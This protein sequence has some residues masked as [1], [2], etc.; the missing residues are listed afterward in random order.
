VVAG[1][2]SECCCDVTGGATLDVTSFVTSAVVR[3]GSL[4]SL[5]C[6]YENASSTAWYRNRRQI[7]THSDK[8]VN[9]RILSDAC[10]TKHI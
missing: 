3:R 8:S 10:V 7:P 5:D 4:T 1:M 2:T 9:H 6:V